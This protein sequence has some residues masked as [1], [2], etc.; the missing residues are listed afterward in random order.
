MCI[1]DRE[2]EPTMAAL[3]PKQRAQVLS[4]TALLQMA[5]ALDFSLSLIHISEPT[6]P[7]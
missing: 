4:L 1:R 7:Y 3:E 5:E 6:R 2:K